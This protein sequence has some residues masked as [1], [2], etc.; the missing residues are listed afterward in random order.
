MADK[1]ENLMI[2]H[3]KRFQATLDRVENKISELTARTANLESGI[4]SITQHLA[5]HASMIAA[6]QVAMDRTNDRLDR[7][8]RRLELAS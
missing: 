3:L 6:Q 5:H 4:A 1:V 2:E 8:E 7:I